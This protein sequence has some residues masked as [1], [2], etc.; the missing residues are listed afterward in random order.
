MQTIN[1]AGGWTG[2]ALPAGAQITGVS[3]TVRHRETGTGGAIALALDGIGGRRVHGHDAD[4]QCGDE[5]VTRRSE[6]PAASVCEHQ[7]GQPQPRVHRVL[8]VHHRLPATASP[9]Q[10]MLDGVELSIT[11]TVAGGGLSPARGC[12][13]QTPYYNPN[14]HSP[15]YND[16]RPTTSCALF[17]V[18]NDPTS[19]G[20][21]HFPR[22]VT[23]WG[24]VYAPSAAM[25]VPVDVL[26]VPVFGRGVVAR[27]LMLG[28]QV[29]ANAQVPVT[30]APLTGGQPQNRTVTLTGQAGREADQGRG[31]RRVLRPRLPRNRTTSAAAR[32]QTRSEGLLLAGDAVNAQGLST[33]TVREGVV[34]GA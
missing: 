33:S 9:R 7:P 27:M 26:S 25:D 23:F 10:V 4:G 2:A 3:A 29:A 34:Q 32:R 21:G 18:A 30:T 31:D 24:T 6:L 15:A 12:I 22:V 1:L 20:D 16:G 8:L 14:D 11:Y 19:G 13:T 28:Y 5:R 17:K